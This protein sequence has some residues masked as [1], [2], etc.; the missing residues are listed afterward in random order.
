MEAKASQKQKLHQHNRGAE[1]AAAVQM[2][3]T[4][5]GV[6]ALEQDNSQWSGESRLLEPEELLMLDAADMEQLARQ[7]HLSSS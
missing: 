1:T 4:F 5:H 3:N 6:A 7:H 2:E